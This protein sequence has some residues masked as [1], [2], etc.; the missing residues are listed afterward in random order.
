MKQG[1]ERNVG[2]VKA[3][4]EI[5]ERIGLEYKGGRSMRNFLESGQKYTV[6]RLPL[7]R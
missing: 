5:P 1:L 4:N 6:V 3:L 2:L 7:L